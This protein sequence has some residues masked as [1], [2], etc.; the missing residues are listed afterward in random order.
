MREIWAKI[1]YLFR[2][3]SH[4]WALDE[5]LEAHLEME[6]EANIERGMSPEEARRLARRAR[7]ARAEAAE[8]REQVSS[9][10]RGRDAPPDEDRPAVHLFTHDERG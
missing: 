8:A 7:P 2:R 1:R 5:E 9:E 10:T 6:I 4:A 3:E